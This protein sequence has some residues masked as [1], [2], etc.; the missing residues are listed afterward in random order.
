MRFKPKN[1]I[2]RWTGLMAFIGFGWI[3]MG[4]HSLFSEKKHGLDWLI[5]LLGALLIF[6][7]Y[8]FKRK[9]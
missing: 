7:Y 2:S 4:V 9:R 3:L 5:I 8:F 1:K 6:N